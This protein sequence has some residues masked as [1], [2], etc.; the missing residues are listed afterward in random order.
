MISQTPVSGSSHAVIA[1]DVGV[2]TKCLKA[3]SQFSETA[4]SDAKP[5]PT[6]NF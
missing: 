4:A 3:I 1:I 6:Q 5:K 2:V